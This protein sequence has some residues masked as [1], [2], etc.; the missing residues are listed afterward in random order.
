MINASIL[1]ATF[2]RRAVVIGAVQG[3]IG[4]LL[5]LRLGYLAIAENEKYRLQSESNRV[6]LTLIPPRRGAI[7]DRGL[8][9]DRV[10]C[11]EHLR[12]GNIHP[13]EYATYEGAY[14]N[15]VCSLIP[16]SYL[17]FLDVEPQV[18]M[19]RVRERSRGCESAVSLEYLRALQ[20]GWEECGDLISF[21]TFVA[22]VDT[23]EATRD[24]AHLDAQHEYEQ[25]RKAK[26]QFEAE[27][28][29]AEREERRQY[30][31]WRNDSGV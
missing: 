21:G 27:D 11:R 17:V 2:E 6:N 25:L 10:F 9:G 15:M 14:Q 5:A 8:P 26:E 13:L 12:V 7:L 24:E 28:A 29:E 30:R 31:E 23:Y 19:D 16:P 20:R 3:G 1:R 22:A 18:A 4:V